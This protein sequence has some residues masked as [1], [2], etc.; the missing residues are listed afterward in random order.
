MKLLKNDIS[1][2]EAHAANSYTPIQ[3]HLY[4]QQKENKLERYHS[5]I[6]M[7]KR[8][9]NKKNILKHNNCVL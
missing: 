4:Q 8:S 9:L 3:G 6:T 5:R 1:S 7:L 2:N